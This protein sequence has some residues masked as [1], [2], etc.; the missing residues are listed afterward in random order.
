MK[1]LLHWNPIF[2]LFLLFAVAPF[3]PGCPAGST[4]SGGSSGAPNG[5][6]A[7]PS[8]PASG[9][10]G[11]EGLVVRDGFDDNR[12]GWPLRGLEVAIKDGTYAFVSGVS[13]LSTTP[14][15]VRSGR[16]AATAVWTGGDPAG[17]FGLVWRCRDAGNFS[18]FSVSGTGEYVFGHYLQTSPKGPVK[19]IET[20]LAKDPALVKANVPIRLQVEFIGKT[21]IGSAGDRRLFEARVADAQALAGVAGVWVR[22]HTKVSFDDFGLWDYDLRAA[23]LAGR[24]LQKGAAVRRAEVRV[25]E[26]LDIDSG[27]T[28]LVDRVWTDDSGVFRLYR[29]PF[30]AYVLASGAAGEQR[31]AGQG[32]RAERFVELIEAHSAKNV[33]L[34]LK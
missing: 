3:A 21:V 34:V 32:V 18:Y 27:K 25:F 16:I 8:L 20:L 26:V 2:R 22:E 29:P 1:T 24:V 4:D 28:A 17:R 23:N 14:R 19:N 15:A 12:Y 11:P 31:K 10:V 13:N 33:D 5:S 7:R 9:A 30:E 6:A